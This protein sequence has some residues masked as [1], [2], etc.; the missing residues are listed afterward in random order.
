MRRILVAYASRHGSTAEICEFIAG[1]LRDAGAEVV[2]QRAR[3]ALAAGPYD[4]YIVG[5]PIYFHLWEPEASAFVKR[6]WKE[7]SRKPFAAFGVGL[8][9]VDG[10]AATRADAE[11]C[12]RS[13]LAREAPDVRPDALA[14]FEGALHPERHGWLS[15]TLLRLIH[16]PIGDFRR[17]EQI[18]GWALGLGYHLAPPQE[19]A[20]PSAP[21]T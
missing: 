8:S 20:A 16:A 19:R 13:S 10:T 11:A 9:M 15:R 3:S 4:A 18:R 14:V 2:V 5:A 12:V 21:P 1:A 17:W 7:L 6:S